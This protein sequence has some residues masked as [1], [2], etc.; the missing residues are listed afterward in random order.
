METNDFNFVFSMMFF[1]LSK[2]EFIRL[3]TLDLLSGNAFNLD[4]D[5]ILQFGKELTVDHT[6][7]TFTTQRKKAIETIF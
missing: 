3:V 2:T 7:L 5:K 1:A 6:I 4:Q